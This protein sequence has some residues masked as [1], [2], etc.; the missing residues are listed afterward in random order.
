MLQD[1]NQQLD[2]TRQMVFRYQKLNAMLMELHKQ[3]TSLEKKTDELKALLEKEEVDVQKLEGKSLTNIFYSVLGNL[4][5]KLQKE[6][7]EALAAKLKYDQAVQEL[8]YIKNEINKQSEEMNQYKMADYTYQQLFEKKKQ[9]LLQANSKTANE[10][11]SYTEKMKEEE[12]MLKEIQEAINAGSQVM[13]HLKNAADSLDSAEGWGTWD[14]LGGGFLSDM[15]KHGHID[16]AKE[17][18]EYTQRA[19]SRFRTELADIKI[20]SNI[21]IETD[22]FAKFADFFFD[23]LIADW[24]MQSRINDSQ[25]SVREVQNQVE[26]VMSKLNSMEFHL[27]NDIGQTKKQVIT[28][29]EQA[30]N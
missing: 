24:C 15:A 29:I 8:E 7:Q 20:D 5:E 17:E 4:D 2:E 30:E 10:I 26:R 1:I 9:M 6:Q 28:L 21:S 18:V 3:K 27:K 16:D 23:G 14:M 19:L 13:N 22:G 12:H 11:L 25:E